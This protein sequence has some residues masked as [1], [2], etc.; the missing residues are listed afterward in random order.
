[1]R[2]GT[3]EKSRIEKETVRA[4]LV[5]NG[6]GAVAMLAVLPSVLDRTGYQALAQGLLVGLLAM[7]VGVVLAI[8]HNH[9][10]SRIP[11]P[12]EPQ[13]V[14]PQQQQNM[15]SQQH[16]L[17]SQH[18]PNQQPMRPVSV[19]AKPAGSSLAL[20]SAACLWLSVVA[21]L[22]AGA[23]VAVSGMTTLDG[24]QNRGAQQ[25]PTSTVGDQ[26]A[27]QKAR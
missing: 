20:A 10:R 18:N 1:M 21:F 26:K 19:E 24:F 6:A 17:G 15:G 22:G 12:G 3:T 2:E 9:L 25:Q 16:G 7:T 13:N 14:R 11:Q 27:K 4:L 5:A 8:L 23:F